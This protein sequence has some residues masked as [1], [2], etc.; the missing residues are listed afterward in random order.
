VEAER[1]QQWA[2]MAP[3]SISL[4]NQRKKNKPKA[5]AG[6]LEGLSTRQVEA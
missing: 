6:G 5:R 2:Q 1:P 3:P 4:K